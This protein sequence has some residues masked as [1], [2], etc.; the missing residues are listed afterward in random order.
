MRTVAR[1]DLGRSV[2]ALVTATTLFCSGCSL[3]LT[4]CE[5][6][7][8]AYVM[9]EY[10][11]A[12]V[13]ASAPEPEIGKAA[14]Y[15]RVLPSVR[16][17]GLQ[18]PE[19]GCKTESA[20]RATGQAKDSDTIM[21]TDCGVWLAEL[22]RALSE[23]NYRV[24]SWGAI[25][26]E[27][28][29]NRLS[30]YE[31]AQRLGAEVVFVVNSMEANDMKRS[32]SD[33]WKATYFH[34]DAAGTRGTRAVLPA[35]VR[36]PLREVARRHVTRILQDPIVGWAGTLD[37]TAVLASTGESIWFF[38]HS[39]TRPRERENGMRFLFRR[40]PSSETYVPVRPRQIV[41][42]VTEDDRASEDSAF[43]STP[44]APLD[45]FKAEK[46]ELARSVARECVSR[47]AGGR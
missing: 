4:P 31:A 1:H 33:G 9:V 7:N 28:Q 13:V 37:V 10:E 36:E 16:T 27:Q 44:A 25:K 34:S 29:N 43:V 11:A 46:H 26:Q 12:A 41:A 15:E 21:I 3:A 39:I 8:A 24:I 30:T 22:E 5:P 2:I 18:F 32:A 40:K 38:R 17:I 23:H 14:G 20:A 45:R 47:F 6:A 19:G 35:M 42:D